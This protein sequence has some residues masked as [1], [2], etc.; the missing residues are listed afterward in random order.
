MK[1]HVYAPPHTGKL[2]KALS[3]KAYLSSANL[4]SVKQS[5]SLIA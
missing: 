2:H 3:V 5:T 1:G 4:T